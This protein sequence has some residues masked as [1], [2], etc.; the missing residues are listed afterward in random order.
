ML[1]ATLA[2][3]LRPVP[4]V[5]AAIYVLATAG[6]LS[7][8]TDGG[9]GAPS[10]LKC[11]SLPSPG[12][13]VVKAYDDARVVDI[14]CRVRRGGL[15]ENTATWY[16]TSDHCYV[17]RTYL[18]LD[19]DTASNATQ[20]IPECAQLDG[21]VSCQLPN[22]AA[23]QIVRDHEPLVRRPHGDVTGTT[24][25]GY[26]HRCATELCTE[27][28]E[29]AG[30]PLSAR[31]AEALLLN[32]IRWATGC[33]RQAFAET[34]VALNEN[35][36]G[37]L[38]SW[39]YGVADCARVQGSRLVRRIAMGEDPALVARQELPRWVVARGY[40]DPVLADRRRAEAELFVEPSDLQA[41][42]RCSSL[43]KMT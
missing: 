25:V 40:V 21:Q 9:D 42:P 12:G 4:I 5:L 7:G 14:D 29:A 33:L 26:G 3:A 39:A 13:L 36:W 10:R 31:T 16:R 18:H 20:R 6:V 2:R 24:V 30:F 1:V 43:L 17:S 41:H 28:R 15:V 38:A 11:R 19:E 27:I 22:R 8:Q 35:Q 23:L 37:A 32:D 34:Q